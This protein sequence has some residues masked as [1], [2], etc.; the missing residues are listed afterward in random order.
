MPEDGVCDITNK[1]FQKYENVYKIK[2]NT[3]KKFYLKK[4]SRG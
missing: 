1:K 3:S 4:K 2:E